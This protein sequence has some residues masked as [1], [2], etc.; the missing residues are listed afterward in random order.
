MRFLLRLLPAFLLLATATCPTRGED[1]SATNRAKVSIPPG[2][3][4][5]VRVT[6][7]KAIEPDSLRCVLD[8]KAEPL[9]LLD[10]DD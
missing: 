6:L 1:A 8:G 2:A 3:E 10:T 5:T 4:Q 9:S 7:P